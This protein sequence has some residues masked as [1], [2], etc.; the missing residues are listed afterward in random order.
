MTPDLRGWT[1]MFLAKLLYVGLVCW[2]RI[3]SP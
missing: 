3:R 1:G 2:R